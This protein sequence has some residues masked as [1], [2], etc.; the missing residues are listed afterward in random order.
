VSRPPGPSK[1]KFKPSEY[2]I[3]D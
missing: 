3:D 1:K 2:K